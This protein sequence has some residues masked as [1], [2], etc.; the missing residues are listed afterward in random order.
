VGYLLKT[1]DGLSTTGR[2][3]PQKKEITLDAKLLEKS[4]Y[5][6][7][8]KENA[9]TEEKLSLLRKELDE[10]KEAKEKTVLPEAKAPFP[11]NPKQPDAARSIHYPVPPPPPPVLPAPS[12]SPPAASAKPAVEPAGD[13]E[14][15]SN[16]QTQAREQK[17]AEV[18]K[19][20]KG[21]SVYLPPSFMEATLLSGLDAP[22][23]ESAKGNPVPVLLRI[24][25]LAI[26]PNRVK[27]D[28]KGCFVIAEGQGN[29]ADERAHLRLVNLS[30]LSKKG[31]A[32]IDQKIKGFV[33]DSDG[34]IGL[35]GTVVSRM[36]S[37]IARS[38][39]AGFF[40][41]VGDAVKSATMTSSINALGTTQTVD[42]EKIAQAGLGSGIAQ[43][44][45]ELQK[46][47]LDLAKQSMP[48]IEIG[49]TRN[50]T[51]VV[52]EGLEL[53]IKEQK[54]GGKKQ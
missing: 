26:L 48:V 3:T 16:P 27:A 29:L 23:V 32:V 34:K 36:G 15:V 52:S 6:E 33:V 37:A 8:R 21:D 19:N 43:G 10:I 49:A 41:G 20:E 54:V 2:N 1:K 45:H 7:G 12:S 28:L 22:T 4:A 50:I 17:Q 51:L 47:Y 39:L 53:E 13:I 11:V 25:D 14:M 35:R 30:C 31:Q 44:A 18:K 40:G 46:F 9:K 38:V 5:L 24:K 42:P